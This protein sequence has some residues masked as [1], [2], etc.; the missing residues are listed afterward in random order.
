[1]N[2]VVI[3]TSSNV[4]NTS[5]FLSSSDGSSSI[6]DP[7]SSS[8]SRE[9]TNGFI[10]VELSDVLQRSSLMESATSGQEKKLL[11]LSDDNRT[12]KARI[13]EL[14]TRSIYKL[15]KVMSARTLKLFAMQILSIIKRESAMDHELYTE[16]PRN[17]VLLRDQDLTQS[18]VDKVTGVIDTGIEKLANMAGKIVDDNKE[19]G[20]KFLE[21]QACSNENI[22]SGAVKKMEDE[23][24]ILLTLAKDVSSDAFSSGVQGLSSTADK[25]S[26]VGTQLKSDV[27]EAIGTNTID[28]FL[29]RAHDIGQQM[30][31]DTDDKF[32]DT[33]LP[34]SKQNVQE[35]EVIQLSSDQSSTNP[36][37]QRDTLLV[38]STSTD[39]GDVKYSS[40][41]W[42]SDWERKLEVTD[43]NKA[44][45]RSTDVFF[46]LK[47]NIS[48]TLTVWEF[49]MAYSSVISFMARNMS[50]ST[51]PRLFSAFTLS[52]L[53][54]I[55]EP[56]ASVTLCILIRVAVSSYA[57][58]SYGTTSD[59]EIR[60]LLQFLVGRTQGPS[61]LRHPPKAVKNLFHY[62][63]WSLVL[64]NLKS[65]IDDE[66]T[67]IHD[68][69]DSL[70]E[71]MHAVSAPQYDDSSV[72]ESTFDRKGPLT[73][74]QQPSENTVQLDDHL[75][76]LRHR[77]FELS[78]R[79][80]TPPKELDDE[81]V[82][83]TTIEVGQTMSRFSVSGD[84]PPRS[85]LKHSSQC[86]KFNVKCVDQRIRKCCCYIIVSAFAYLC[87]VRGRLPISVHLQFVDCSRYTKASAAAAAAAREQWRAIRNQ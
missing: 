21:D 41:K 12:D 13:V 40:E 39:K 25:A 59:G 54:H 52:C 51:S 43:D 77:G 2:S 78:P 70:I 24:R 20:S 61:T 83:P 46:V 66:V 63:T 64:L 42:Y 79:P 67:D 31:S 10:K 50:E 65:T 60:L 82:K 73:I 5:L 37:V 9:S 56:L 47:R 71:R 62:L 44:D 53:S 84:H 15:D 27:N 34:E 75:D 17:T 4:E 74:P 8:S 48:V 11:E 76:Q 18:A 55:L 85:I 7:S 3:N 28:P 72:E 87:Y 32:L 68:Q 57:S 6:S 29:S 33:K 35:E 23:D 69:V 86:T 45:A 14:I 49:C 19:T 58:M 26:N 16:E 36:A 30:L 22:M 1:M 81:D 80:P 38:D